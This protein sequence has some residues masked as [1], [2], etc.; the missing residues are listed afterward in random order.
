MAKPN[1]I[2]ERTVTEGKGRLTTGDAP[3]TDRRKGLA[4]PIE[5]CAH[6]VETMIRNWPRE[7]ELPA[8]HEV[9]A[10]IKQMRTVASAMVRPITEQD[11]FLDLI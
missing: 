7:Y 6:M 8:G 9:F 10:L 11:D 1:R 4:N 3:A 2:A 5:D